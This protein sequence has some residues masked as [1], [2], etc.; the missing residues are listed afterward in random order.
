M[1][2]TLPT[3]ATR[4]FCGPNA[5]VFIGNQSGPGFGSIAWR[6]RGE[7]LA[8][9]PR[10]GSRPEL[11]LCGIWAK[12]GGKGRIGPVPRPGAAVPSPI[13]P[14]RIR[15]YCVA[16]LAHGQPRLTTMFWKGVLTFFFQDGLKHKQSPWWA[17]GLRGPI[18][19]IRCLSFPRRRLG[20]RAGWAT[21]MD[22][23]EERS[24]RPASTLLIWRGP[25]SHIH[26]VT[27]AREAPVFLHRKFTARRWRAWHRASSSPPCFWPPGR[28][29]GTGTSG[30]LVPG[31]GVRDS[32]PRP[33]S[34]CRH[35]GALSVTPVKTGTGLVRS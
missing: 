27:V 14:L 1:E 19:S 21:G 6:A 25:D 4:S 10:P 8:P 16:S 32:W 12:R 18:G 22:V 23:S 24:G 30:Q 20:P 5:G 7:G 11:L 29:W 31:N 28:A 2:S 9:S 17:S 35:L 26:P 15:L 13:L 34:L 3:T 33:E